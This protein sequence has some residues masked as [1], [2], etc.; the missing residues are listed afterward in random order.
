MA[1]WR[2]LI[3]DFAAINNIGNKAKWAR[4]TLKNIGLKSSRGL[5]EK[6]G[7]T[8]ARIG[9]RNIL[10]KSKIIHTFRGRFSTNLS[11]TKIQATGTKETKEIGNNALTSGLKKITDN[12]NTQINEGNYFN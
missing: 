5:V 1:W 9:S 4:L 12:L 3:A 8:A 10:G 2:Q 11:Q 7:R 6:R